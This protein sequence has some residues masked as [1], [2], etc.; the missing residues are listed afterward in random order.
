MNYSDD[1]LSPK[2]DDFYNALMDAHSGLPEAESH[3]LNARLVL[4][5]ANQIG[6]L[7]TLKQL[8]AAARDYVND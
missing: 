6:D 5:M 1:K 2:Q 8:L 7:E 4:L 3:A